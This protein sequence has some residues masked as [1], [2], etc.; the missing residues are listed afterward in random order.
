MQ[1]MQV[2]KRT[3][4]SACAV[5]VATV[6]GRWLLTEALVAYEVWSTSVS[7]RVDLSEDFGMGMVGLLI[8]DPVALAG[9]LIAGAATLFLLP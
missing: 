1:V 6:L 8:I 3:V 5:L 2:L 9:G 7:A 4:A